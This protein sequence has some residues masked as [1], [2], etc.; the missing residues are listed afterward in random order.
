MCGIAGVVLNKAGSVPTNQIGVEMLKA[1][2]HRG[3]DGRGE[4][5]SEQENV[6]LGHR[7]LAIIDPE[8]GKQPLSN[9]DGTIWITFN[10]CIY[11]YLEL[12]QN[13]RSKGHRFRTY[14]DTEVIVHAYEEF[15]IECVK[16]FIG[17]FSF[18]IWDDRKKI[19]FCARD[20][21]GVKPFYYW[22]GSGNFIFASEIKALLATGLINK[23][24]NQSSIQE[25]LVFQTVLG[26]KTLFDGV[27]KLLPGHYMVVN[28]QGQIIENK[29]YWDL[30]FDIDTD[31]TEEYFV[32]RLRT[33]LDDAVKIRLRSD[34][35]LGAHLSGGLDSSTVVSLASMFNMTGDSLKTFTGAFGEG[36]KFDETLY[37][38]MVAENV[39]AQYLE[40]YPTEVD[41]IESL[42]K[43]IYHMDEPAAGPGVFPQYM[44]S[45]LASE[46]VKVVLGGQ[47]GDEIFAG[48]TRYL[49]GYLEEC[50]KGAIQETDKSGDYAATLTSI[51][52]SLPMLKQYVPMLKYFWSEGLFETQDRRY[53]RLMDRSGGV[54]EIYN[55]EIFNNSEDVFDSFCEVFHGSNSASFLN[56]MLYFDLKVHLPALLHVEDRTS[57][58][59]GIES[60]VP[61]LDHRI[62]DLL[63]TIPPTI[64]FK[65]GQPK[66]LFRKVVKNLLPEQVFNR[67]DK[68]GF[69][70]PLHLWFRNSLGEF[71]KEVLLD[72]QAKNRG[73]FNSDTLE[74]TIQEEKDFGRV[75]WGALCL[76][77]WFKI[78][79]DK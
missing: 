10:G 43:I 79:V 50:L 21:M 4:W 51:I 8:G 57:M 2:I 31:H 37:A 1:L 59:W 49:V 38:K 19:L 44:V 42:S 61:L 15:G 46:H 74:K 40:T 16:Y 62:A 60:R 25:Y 32:D 22:R 14:T 20:R 72:E 66:Y 64:K 33:L 65:G 13:L 34:V 56:R 48:Y 17:M 76:E 63:A 23:K 5:T 27:N 12:A 54:K 55:H 29:K 78:F 45:K 24:P 75:I 58:A 6:W 28:D 70:V 9:E 39:G 68:M 35:A 36:E 26:E 3:P 71:A 18:A 77:L 47:G 30:S 7:R 11:N 52:P 41:F 53:F 67:K 73:I 69:P